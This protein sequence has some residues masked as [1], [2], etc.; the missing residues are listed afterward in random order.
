MMSPST[1]DKGIE[2]HISR[3]T[4]EAALAL[5]HMRLAAVLGLRKQPATHPFVKAKLQFPAPGLFVPQSALW[6]PWILMVPPARET[7][8]LQLREMEAWVTNDT[9]L[10]LSVPLTI[11]PPSLPYSPP[12]LD[13]EFSRISI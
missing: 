9:R 6:M 8:P 11:L 12:K 4:A 13:A 7:L 1:N 5:W 3:A 2:R 10:P